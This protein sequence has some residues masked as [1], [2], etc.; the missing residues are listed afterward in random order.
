M[1]FNEEQITA[2]CEQVVSKNEVDELMQEGQTL[3]DTLLN[4]SEGFMKPTVEA[5]QL[6]KMLAKVLLNLIFAV[7]H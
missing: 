6:K 4:Q 7:H 2:V 5:M 3:I 1:Q